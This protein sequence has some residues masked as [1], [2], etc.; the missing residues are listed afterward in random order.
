[1]LEFLVKY[2]WQIIVAVIL[3]IAV[4]LFCYEQNNRIVVTRYK[5]NK[6]AK[7]IKIL[8]LSDLHSKQ[9][10]KFNTKLLNKV[11]NEQPDIIV[12]TGDLINDKG[13]NI[14]KT[15]RFVSA[16]SEIAPL[17]YVCGNHEHRLDYFDKLIEKISKAGAI[18]LR[19]K[20]ED[21]TINGE[22]INIL[23][24]D[25]NQAS[26][27]NYSERRKG[28][29]KYKDYSDTF[30]ELAKKDGIKI[31]LTHYPENFALIGECSYNQYDFDVMFAG[32]AHGGQFVLPFVGSV[33]SPGQGLFPK[34]AKGEYG[35]KP[36]LIVSRGLGN[37]E[38]PLRLFNHPEIVVF[39]I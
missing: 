15:M 6:K 17:Y 23:G 13:R 21:L 20:I 26:F 32:H 27:K 11:K 38:F 22:E 19:D 5:S 7:G 8:Q 28:N 36:K 14:D 4:S 31:V 1:M 30:K 39:E 37:S 29:F 2:L 16:L 35:E 24:L 18:V 10:G 34:Y 25:E 3:V 33:Y 9:F 12:F